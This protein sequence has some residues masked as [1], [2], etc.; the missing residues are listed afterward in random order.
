MS[1]CS[2]SQYAISQRIAD[3][4]TSGYSP[5]S[6]DGTTQSSINDVCIIAR[7]PPEAAARPTENPVLREKYIEKAVTGS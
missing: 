2:S 7:L 6:G 5:A 1:S 3:N 4:P